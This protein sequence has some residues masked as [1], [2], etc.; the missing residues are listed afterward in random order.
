MLKLIRKDFM[1]F[2][3]ILIFQILFVFLLMSIGLF[4]D[5]NGTLLVV[6]LIF[7]PI[8][9]PTILLISDDKYQSLS[10]GLPTTRSIYVLSKYVF[11]FVLSILLLA[12]G[13][14]YGYVVTNYIVTDG[15]QMS[16][17]FTIQGLLFVSIPVLL[18]N[19]LTFPIFFRFSKKNASI[20]LMMIFGL[21]LVGFIVGLVYFE[22]TVI[23]SMTYSEKEVFPVLMNLLKD[24]V[25]SVG[26]KVFLIQVVLF[27]VGYMASSIGL[28]LF[29]YARKD[30]GG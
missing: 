24:Y 8:S 2:N 13:L 27:L 11:G 30:I 3:Y 16:Q 18:I 20:I 4:I 5:K 6:G 7:Y 1:A 19:G 10:N 15:V 28:S 23:S 25:L 29:V 17:I 22:K 9:L 26:R 21:I 12:A 14:S